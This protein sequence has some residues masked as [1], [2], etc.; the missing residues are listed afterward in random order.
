MFCFITH[1]YLVIPEMLFS[2]IL[3]CAAMALGG[4]KGGSGTPWV[5]VLNVFSGGVFIAA[6]FMHLLPEAEQG[7]RDLSDSWN[8]EVRTTTA[9]RCL[10]VFCFLLI[11]F[12]DS[13]FGFGFSVFDLRF[14]YPFEYRYTFM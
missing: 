6:G 9:V 12:G 2:R 7:L 4:R 5:S 13:V 14:S 1:A 8:F 11:G 3:L 10:V